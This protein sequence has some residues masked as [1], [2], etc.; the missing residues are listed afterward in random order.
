MVI[1]KQGNLQ[2]SCILCASQPWF[3]Q[4]IKPALNFTLSVR[5]FH[6]LAGYF[7]ISQRTCEIAR[8]IVGCVVPKSSGTPQTLLLCCHPANSCLL[9]GKS[10]LYR[11]YLNSAV[12]ALTS[13]VNICLRLTKNVKDNRSLLVLTAVC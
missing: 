9:G 12:T 3:R 8:L 7:R 4:H 10:A 1:C 11:C 5:K 6:K 2:L 13:F